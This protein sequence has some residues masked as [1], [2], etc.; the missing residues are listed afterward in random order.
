MELE[1][2]GDPMGAREV[3]L[4]VLRSPDGEEQTTITLFFS[5]PTG[6]E[7]QPRGPFYGGEGPWFERDLGIDVSHASLDP[8]VG[9]RSPEIG[10]L[11]LEDGEELRL[12]VFI[13]R[14]IIEVFANERQC[15]T[16]RAYPSREDSNGV[17]ETRGWAT[18]LGAQMQWG[19]DDTQL[20]F[21]DMDCEAWQ[22][23]GV[24]MDVATGER[25]ELEGTV[26][27]VSHD[28]TKSASPCLSF[29]FERNR[30]QI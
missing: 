18:Q 16:V 2:V 14:S 4:R 23:F 22:P 3:G 15:L 21:N 24:E 1:A 30:V 19:A 28:G 6:A 11:Y 17:A 27:M 29:A 7:S 5:L 26:Y 10:P 8:H 9:S 12:R 20:F 25:R 13:D